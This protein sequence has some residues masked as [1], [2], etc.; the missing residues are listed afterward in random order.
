M[1]DVCLITN[2]GN[3]SC[4]CHDAR[5]KVSHNAMYCGESSYEDLSCQRCEDMSPRF[6]VM[7]KRDLQETMMNECVCCKPKP[8]EPVKSGCEIPDTDSEEEQL[9]VVREERESLC[10]DDSSMK[11]GLYIKGTIFLIL[12]SILSFILYKFSQSY[13]KSHEIMSIMFLLL[14]T[15]IIFEPKYFIPYMIIN[16]IC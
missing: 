8:P 7:A 1:P 10:E 6:R 14:L 4:P 11:I 16:N 3:K 9:A 15:L 5:N 13:S 2:D 12:F